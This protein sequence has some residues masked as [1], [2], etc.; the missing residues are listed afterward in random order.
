M[1]DQPRTF[2][3]DRNNDVSGVSGTGIVAWGCLFPDGRAV[4]RWATA[5][6]STVVYDN[7]QQVIAIH[8]H[9]GGT[10]VKFYDGRP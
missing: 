2:Y 1:N 5:T 3:L 10:V 4:V 9:Q 7:I 8:G 6:A